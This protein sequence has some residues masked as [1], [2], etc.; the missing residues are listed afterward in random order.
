MRRGSGHKE[1]STIQGLDVHAETIFVAIAE[2]DGSVR[3]LGVIANR[4]ES[5]RKLV[6]KLGSAE[7][8]K[9]C[10]VAGP[11]GYVLCWQL[12]ELG[13]VYEVIAPTLMPMKSGDRV[14]TNRRDAGRL[15]RSFRSR[16][17]MGAG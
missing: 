8:L 11:T 16:D 9:A 10:Y 6:K 17:L 15:A 4:A 2:P 5:I 14:K 7:Q 1:N 3:S 12:A 13:V